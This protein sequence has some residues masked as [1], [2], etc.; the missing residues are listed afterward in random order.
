MR[1]LDIR[2]RVAY[3]NTYALSLI[4]HL[5]QVLPPR[6]S[7]VMVMR[8]SLGRFLWAGELFRVPLDVM[9]LPPAR[10]G[11]SLHDPLL[12]SRAMFAS[13]WLTA[14]RATQHS[15]GWLAA[16]PPGAVPRG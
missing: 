14:E 4:W 13:R 3:C 5:A 7:D 16:Y 9:V 11:L 12:R 1:V 6:A 8:K 10:G 15:G 2:Q